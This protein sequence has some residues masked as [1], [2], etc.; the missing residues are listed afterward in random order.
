MSEK[1][2]IDKYI[3]SQ[4]TMSRKE[5][6]KLIKQKAVKVNSIVCTSPDFKVS[7]DT[8]KILIN[9]EAI[10]YKKY[11]YYM[12]N[13]PPGVLS[14]SED[15]RAQT[16]IDLLP[17]SMKRPN[18]FPCGRLDKDTTGLLIITDDGD[19]AHRVLSPNK[20]VYKQYIA[21]LDKNANEDIVEEFKKGIALS[22]GTICKPSFVRKINKNMVTLDICEGKFHQ[23]KRMFSALGY[24]VIGLKR[25]RIGGLF[26][27]NTLCIGQA[28]ELSQE[29]A[30]LALEN[31][32]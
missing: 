19:Y 23:V 14:A 13:K 22:D 29:T 6:K 1:I 3:S 18:L 26:L 27:D 7:T 12:L 11:V 32:V 15:K 8:D 31:I 30:F 20:N 21:T 4:T 9:G 17:N 24:T 16:V 5:I 28:K 2:R 10:K 25:V